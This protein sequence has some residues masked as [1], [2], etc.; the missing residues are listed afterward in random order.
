MRIFH[1]LFGAKTFKTQP[2]VVKCLIVA[3]FTTLEKKYLQFLSFPDKFDF[4]C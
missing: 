3:Y 1:P 2:K 4:F